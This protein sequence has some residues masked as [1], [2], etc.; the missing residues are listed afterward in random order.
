MVFMNL[1]TVF[2]RISLADQYHLDP[3]YKRQ[4][5]ASDCAHPHV[6]AGSQEFSVIK[7][8]CCLTKIFLLRR[9]RYKYYKKYT[10]GR[11]FGRRLQQCGRCFMGLNRLWQLGLDTKQLVRYAARL[12]SDVAFF[13]YDTSYALG[14]GR[15]ELIKPLKS[16]QNCGM[17][18]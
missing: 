2:E 14:T 1:R 9:C 7:Q 15:G 3:Q 8:R 12:G 16:R 4:N 10:C 17:C 5:N 13:L 18:L 11:G 6:P